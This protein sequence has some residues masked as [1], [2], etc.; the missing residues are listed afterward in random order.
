M[1]NDNALNSGPEGI[2]NERMCH[3]AFNS[4]TGDPYFSALSAFLLQSHCTEIT[5][6]SSQI[7]DDVRDE[8]L[9]AI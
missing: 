9:S 4:R 2:V 6:V 3:A 1:W 8:V 7:A 5:E